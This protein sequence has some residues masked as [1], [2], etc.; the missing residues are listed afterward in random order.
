[1]FSHIVDS[2][3]TFTAVHSSGL[4]DKVGKICEFYQFDNEKTKKML[5]AANLHDIGKL[6]IPNS[7]LDKNG[8]LTDD[9]FAL[10][11]SHTYYTRAALEKIDGFEDIT[12]WAANHHEKL[13]GNGYPYGL[14]AKEISFESRLMGC[15]DMYQ[16]LTETR[17]YREGLG[18]EKT[19]SILYEHAQK[20][21]IDTQIV[22]DIDSYFQ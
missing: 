19:M 10:I 13:D 20:G 14:N 4:S 16:A 5:I 1:V 12:N 15:L 21:F 9:E 3:S 18:H 7:I 6:A 11:K 17:P 22:K 2:N 8:K